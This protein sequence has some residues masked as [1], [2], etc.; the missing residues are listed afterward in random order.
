MKV[1]YSCVDS[2]TSIIKRHN[3]KV[4]NTTPANSPAKT[5]NCKKDTQCLLDGACL[6]DN[7]A[8][9]A[10]IEAPGKQ[11]KKYIGMTEYSFKPFLPTYLPTYLLTYLLTY[12][13][14]YLLQFFYLLT[15]LPTCLPT[16]LLTYLL[17]YLPTCTYVLTY[18]PTYM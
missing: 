15:Y 13:P 4:L 8:Y 1:S 9:E 3:N 5:C 10:E 18:L 6:T 12:L 2:M 11:T 7:L 14:T 16:Y 17:T